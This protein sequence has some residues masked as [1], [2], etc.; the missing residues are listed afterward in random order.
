MSFYPNGCNDAYNDDGTYDDDLDYGQDDDY[1]EDDGPAQTPKSTR[2]S[3][4]GRQLKR[5][6][7]KL[8]PL[9]QAIQNTAIDIKPSRRRPAS[10][11][12]LRLRLH[13]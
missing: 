5:W 1:V 4:K 10:T 8:S 11:S 12:L 9:T 13:Q 6:D 3:T 7:G 2:K